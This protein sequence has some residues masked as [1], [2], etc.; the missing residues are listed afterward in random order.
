MTLALCAFLLPAF[1]DTEPKT[2]TDTPDDVVVI[3]DENG[4]LVEVIVIVYR[5]KRGL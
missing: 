4:Q 2:R 5:D 3:T 1:A